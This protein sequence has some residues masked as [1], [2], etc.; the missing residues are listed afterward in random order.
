MLASVSKW[1]GLI[2]SAADTPA[3]VHEAFRQLN[4]G[5][6]C[7]VVIEIPPDV[8]GQ[9]NPATATRAAHAAA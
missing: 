6:R 8:R 5:R 4:G 9:P 7:P 3:L 1:Q 2:K